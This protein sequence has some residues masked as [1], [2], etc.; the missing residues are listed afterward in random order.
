MLRYHHRPIFFPGN[1]LIVFT[2]LVLTILYIVLLTL[3]RLAL[4]DFPRR[5]G[6]GNSLQARPQFSLYGGARCLRATTLV[7]Q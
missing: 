1:S 6:R 4:S 2:R 7:F 5:D 3:R